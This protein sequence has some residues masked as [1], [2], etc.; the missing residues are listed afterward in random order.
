M[1][2]YLTYPL[3]PPKSR[4]ARHGHIVEL[5]F[6]DGRLCRRRHLLRLPLGELEVLLRRESLPVEQL[7]LRHAQ[8]AGAAVVVLT[9]AVAELVFDR[10]GR[11]SRRR[12]VGQRAV[13][14]GD[15]VVAELVGSLGVRDDE[16]LLEVTLD[17]VEF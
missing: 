15:V 5:V 1:N 4:L 10:G 2:A 3:P 13:A 9:V 8:V 11:Q 6:V 16:Q 14:V 17:Q 12:L 7:V